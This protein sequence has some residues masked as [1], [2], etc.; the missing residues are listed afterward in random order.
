MCTLWMCRMCRYSLAGSSSGGREVQGSRY[1][2]NFMLISYL[3]IFYGSIMCYHFHSIDLMRRAVPCRV[4]AHFSR[5]S[6]Y[7]AYACDF[8][9][10]FFHS[11]F[12]RRRRRRSMSTEW[13]IIF[14]TR[15]V[16][17]T[18]VCEL[19]ALYYVELREH[20]LL[21]GLLA[22][23]NNNNTISQQRRNKKWKSTRVHSRWHG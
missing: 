15:Y 13:N 12:H 3:F 17:S 4:W 19:C 18:C 1:W 5:R 20:Y 14:H 23:N 10:F 16:T 7:F 2:W 6:L 11:S 8:F 21:F 9:I 22:A